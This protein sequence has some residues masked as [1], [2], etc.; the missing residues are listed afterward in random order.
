MFLRNYQS[1][2]SEEL[3]EEIESKYS[4]RKHKYQINKSISIGTLNENIV[5]IFLQKNPEKILESLKAV[6]LS[7]VVPKI[8]NRSERRE[9]DR[10]RSR[11]KPKVLKNRKRVL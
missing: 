6:F 11:K 7:N 1:L 2:L 8:E 10:Y 5:D 4:H 9:K 3:E